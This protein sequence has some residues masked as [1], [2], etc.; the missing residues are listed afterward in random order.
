MI[1]VT[2]TPADIANYTTAQATVPLVVM[3]LPHI[4]PL[5]PAPADADSEDIFAVLQANGAVIGGQ[6]R[7]SE[8]K[9]FLVET[10]ISTGMQ[11]RFT[12][13]DT[14]RG[15]DITDT[16]P[17]ALQTG[18]TTNQPGEPETRIYKGA[19]YVKGADG[20]WHLK[21]F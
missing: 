10:S 8:S 17:E 7:A 16:K 12:A 14:S 19:T 3:G 4:N 11:A 20:Q 13:T 2:F 18:S 15:T 5:T 1:S 6:K 21:Q 9:P